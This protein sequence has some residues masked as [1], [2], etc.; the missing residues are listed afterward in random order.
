[1]NHSH[2]F[3]LLELILTVSITSILL[4]IGLPSLA[5]L[6]SKSQTNTAAEAVLAAIETTR[7]TA[8]FHNQPAVLLAKNNNWSDG[9]SIF[10]DENKNGVLDKD[11]RI[12]I[13]NEGLKNVLVTGNATM[14][15]Q[16]TFIGSGEARRVNAKGYGGFQAGTLKIC[17]EESGNGYSLIL[18]RGGRTRITKLTEKDCAAKK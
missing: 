7:S 16:I 6:I 2:G 12:L 10:V 15:D 17:P 11:E 13:E 3:T 14:K 9:W 18:S 8:V 5:N 4:T 1:M